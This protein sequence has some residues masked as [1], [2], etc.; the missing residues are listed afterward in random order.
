[1]PG[2]RRFG[3]VQVSIARFEA[4]SLARPRRLFDAPKDRRSK[5]RL[6]EGCGYGFRLSNIFQSLSAVAR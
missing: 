4:A 5:L 2:G 1:V 6:Y 3:K